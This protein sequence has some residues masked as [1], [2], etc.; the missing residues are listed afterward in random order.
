M[1]GDEQ[2]VRRELESCGGASAVK[3]IEVVHAEQQVEMDDSPSQILRTKRNSSI[4]TGLRL[5]KQGE[6]AAFFSAGNT[7]AVMACAKMI[8]KTLPGGIDRPAIAAV[9]PTVKGVTV[10]CDVGANV[11]CKIGNYIQFAIM[12]SAYSSLVMDKEA[13]PSVGL[14]S[15]GEEEVKGGSDITK[16]VFK[17]LQELGNSSV[18]NFYGNVEGKDL[19]RGGTS[20]V[21][22]VDGFSG[23]VALKVSESAGWYVSQ[24]LKEEIRSSLLSKLGAIFMIPALKR[25]KK[26]S[27]SL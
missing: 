16:N 1:V 7:G 25:I 8:L 19:F 9:M 26:E 10:M 14:M 27:G 2:Q 23:N 13:P 21:V 4:H 22:V 15:V 24:M 6:G 12:A 18:I 20:D 3:N 5:V 11:D 17:F